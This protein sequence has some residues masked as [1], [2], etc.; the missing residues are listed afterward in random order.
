MRRN[1]TC[2]TDYRAVIKTVQYYNLEKN[3]LFY[4]WWDNSVVI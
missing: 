3:E 2:K 1:Y 4:K